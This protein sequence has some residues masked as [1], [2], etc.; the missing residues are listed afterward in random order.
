[1]WG[2]EEKME[3]KKVRERKRSRMTIRTEYRKELKWMKIR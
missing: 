3:Q 1:M 2:G